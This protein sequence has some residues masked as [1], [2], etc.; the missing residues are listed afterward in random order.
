[1]A[2]RSGTTSGPNSAR[3]GAVH[4]SSAQAQLIRGHVV[5][6]QSSPAGTAATGA[7]PHDRHAGAMMKQG[8]GA[9]LV[10]PRHT[11]AVP[12]AHGGNDSYKT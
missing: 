9:A 2:C 1:M 5:H 11:A 4:R 3:N 8:L 12:N 10:P 6:A 7:T